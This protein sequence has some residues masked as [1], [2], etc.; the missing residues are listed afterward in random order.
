MKRSRKTKAAAGGPTS[1][2]NDTVAAADRG[3][4]VLNIGSGYPL[5][6]Q[7]PTLFQGPE[8]RELRHDL[9]PASNPDILCP[10]TELSPVATGS[11]DAIWSSHNLIHLPRHEVPTALDEFLRVLRPGGLLLVRVLDLR[12]ICEFI[13]ADGLDKEVYRAPSGP[14][15]AL[16]MLYGHAES[17]GQ[18]AAYMAHRSGF[19]ATT[20]GQL[21]FVAGFVGVEIGQVDLDLQA[22]AYKPPH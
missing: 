20:L 14:I 6:Q 7:L 17:I 15:T 13:A 10:L 8:W 18:G 12:R 2:N 3:F 1:E 21:L 5:R 11:V 4:T 22:R 19:T 16:D 9:D